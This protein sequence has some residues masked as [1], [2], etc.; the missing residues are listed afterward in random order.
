MNASMDMNATTTFNIAS[1]IIHPAVFVL[2][3]QSKTLSQFDAEE[4]GRPAF[5]TLLEQGLSS[6]AGST[7]V[8]SRVSAS[9]A[10]YPVVEFCLSATCKD[11]EPSSLSRLVVGFERGYSALVAFRAGSRLYSGS[12][13]T[14]SPGGVQQLWPPLAKPEHVPVPCELE[15][16]QCFFHQGWSE[17][18]LGYGDALALGTSAFA[19][20]A[21]CLCLRPEQKFA[22]EA[23]KASK[24]AR[25]TLTNLVSVQHPASARSPLGF[26]ASEARHPQGI[27]RDFGP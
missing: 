26:A 2:I 9:S 8:I 24:Q 5:K 21:Y 7:V 20:L 23:A 1:A 13:W 22:K 14:Q 19:L 4:G 12:L 16:M 18:P 10:G 15:L 27:G 11:F 3:V 17:A 6:A 25:A